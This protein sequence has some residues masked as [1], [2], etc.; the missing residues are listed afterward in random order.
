MTT[1]TFPSTEVASQFARAA[2]SQGHAVE[3]VGETVVVPRRSA[4]VTLVV[5]LVGAVPLVLL[6]WFAEQW[7]VGLPRLEPLFAAPI[8]SVT[9]LLGVTGAAIGAVVGSLASLP[10]AAG[11]SP[12]GH[13]VRVSSADVAHLVESYGGVTVAW[14]RPPAPEAPVAPALGPLRV[15]AWLL[16]VLT[17][18]V[19]LTATAY[20]WWLSA[21]YGHGADQSTRIGYT[22]KNV[23]RIPADTPEGAGTVL[24][25]ILGGDATG[26]V[27]N[28]IAAAVAAPSAAALGLGLVYGGD[29]TPGV[30]LDSVRTRLLATSPVVVLIASEEPAYALPAA[31]AAAQF[32]AP[33]VT[34]D[35]AADVLADVRDKVLL[36]AA[37]ERLVPDEALVDLAAFGAVE[38]VAADG[39]YRHALVWAERAWGD[40]GWG[41]DPSFH[42]D[43]YVNFTLT[44]PTDPGFAAAGLPMA[45][46]GNYGPL[47]YTPHDDL[48]E[49][50]DQYLWRLSPDFYVAPSDGP[51]I[52]LRVVGGPASVSYAAQAR[53]DLAV[54]THAYRQ[55]ATGMSGIASL[56]WAWFVVGLAGFVWALF[57]IPRRLPDTGFYPRLYWPLAM[58]VLGP[59]GILAFF[60]SYR[61]RPVNR[62]GPMPTFV[63]PPWSQAVSAT[64][65]GMGVG[66]ALMIA[67]MY[68]FELNGL[69]LFTTFAFTPFFWLGSPM[70]AWMWGLMVLPAIAV[71]TLFFMGPMMSD[72]QGVSYGRGVRLAAPV[73]IVSMVAA[74]VGMWTLS[75][76]WMNWQGLMSTEDLWS[77]VAPLWW[78][79][80]MGFLTALIPN[81]LLVRAGWKRGGM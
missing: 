37:P 50:T 81:Y 80:F 65:M 76:W 18:G 60:A 68:L 22:F 14:E 75:W 52:N 30:D 8:G 43:T 71:S 47:L 5:A 17:A 49:L 41:I 35:E 40:F 29:T 45:W 15:V 27:A 28:P 12:A 55:Q 38:R 36:V 42:R 10:R 23:Q 19:I 64:I 33:V 61:G 51:F 72:M 2:R 31:Y 39:I 6:G 34:L 79:A 7:M 3:V 74:S 73:V 25:D 54:E 44:N 9:L 4:L 24:A 58:L 70:A 69:P 21:D 26:V 13:T 67:S 59:V 1:V 66:M 62:L 48:D 32:R 63:R 53:P 11:P 20:I 16:V 56:G 57:A 46:L 77:W 78:A